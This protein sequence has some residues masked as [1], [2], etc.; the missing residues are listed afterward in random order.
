M[1]DNIRKAIGLILL[2]SLLSVGLCKPLKE[3]L[4]IP[5]QMRVFETQTQAIETSLSVNAQEKSSEAFT[6]EKD[7]HEIKVTGKKSGQSELVYDLAGFPIKKTKVQVLPDLK[8]IPGGQSIGVKLHSVGVLVVGFHQINTSEGKK[9]PGESAGI[10]AGD[11]IIEMNGQKIEKMNDVAPFIQKAGNTG[12]SLD[13]LIKRDKQKIKTKLIPQKDEAE[14]KYRIGLYI[15]DSAAGIGTMTFYEP[16]TKKYGALGHVISDMDT[17]KPIVVEDGEI[18]KSTVTSIEKGTGGNP[19]EKLARFSSERKT[20]GDINRNSPFGIFGTLH[21]PIKNKISDKALPVAFS[22]EVKKG[23]AEILTVI[24]DDKVEKFDIEI[25]S[26]TPQKFPATKG[27]VLKITDPRLL[28]ETGG[29]VQ[30][31]SGSPIIQNGKVVG[32]VTHVFVNDPTSGYGVH[33][34]WMLS[35]AGID[36]YGKEKAS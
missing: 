1:R 13:L 35:E 6:V 32:A 10:T 28:K 11:I 7:P 36:I 31:M 15:R 18:V 20:I 17:K 33:I 3:Y 30:G 25:V 23:P 22:N 8:V 14:G 12:E 26:T 19:G 34:E 21:Q 24:D 4:L 27:M 16:K 9:S 29:I 2:V 5:T